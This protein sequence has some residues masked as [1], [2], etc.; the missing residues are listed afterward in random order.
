[1]AV[2]ILVTRRLLLTSASKFNIEAN[3]GIFYLD[4]ENDRASRNVKTPNDGVTAVANGRCVVTMA[5]LV[6]SPVQG[7]G[8]STFALRP[9]VQLQERFS[10]DTAPC[11]WNKHVPSNANTL[12]GGYVP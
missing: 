6:A 1:M 5:A 10:N 8:C 2:F 12:N 4:P 9:S 7:T 11:D 3:G